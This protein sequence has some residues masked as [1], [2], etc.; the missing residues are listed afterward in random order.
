[1]NKPIS[2][3]FY[4]IRGVPGA[5]RTTTAKSLE[6]TYK[7]HDLTTSIIEANDFFVKDGVYNFDPKLL[8]EAHDDCIERTKQALT[9][10]TT[11]I[12]IVTNTFVHKWE[13][14][15]YFEM[16][17]YIKN[18]VVFDV[19]IAQGGKGSTHD[20]PLRTIEKMKRNF[21][22][23][24]VTE[25]NKYRDIARATNYEKVRQ[26]RASIV[27]EYEIKKSLNLL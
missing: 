6:L 13:I 23:I 11:D 15:P 22:Q 19:I 3:R 10:D 21:E 4:L 18:I 8:Q 2:K 9:D 25:I 20:V 1:M 17:E 7:A 16:M 14:D 12:V 5:G 27:A 26:L 24:P